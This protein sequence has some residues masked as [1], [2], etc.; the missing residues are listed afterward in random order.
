MILGGSEELKPKP[1]SRCPVQE[2]GLRGIHSDYA[3]NHGEWLRIHAQT[4]TTIN[5]PERNHDDPF[6]EAFEDDVDDPK[7]KMMVKLRVKS[8]GEA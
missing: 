5:H 3:S 8:L 7:M 6:E 2:A 1:N 4:E